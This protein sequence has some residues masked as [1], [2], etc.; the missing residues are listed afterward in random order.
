MITFFTDP[1]LGRNA[2]SHTTPD[3]RKKLDDA[4][5][6][7]AIYASTLY[8]DPTVCVGDL[9]HKAHNPESIIVQGI[10]VASGCDLIIAGNHDL[11]NRADAVPSLGVLA[12]ALNADR[13][14]V[15][16]TDVG[17]TMIYACNI[18]GIAVTSI[19]HHSSQDLFEQ[20]IDDACSFGGEIVCLHAN[21]ESPYT[22]GVNTSLNLTT[23]LA[24]KLLTEFK[25]IVMG[26][27]HNH[28]WEMDGRL[29]IL[30]N[31]HPTSFSDISHKYAW[32]YDTE[33]SQFYKSH[34][35][36]MDYFYTKIEVTDLLDG[37]SEVDIPPMIEFIEVVGK[38]HSTQES[39][40]LAQRMNELWKMH[41][42]SLY[43]LR[44]NTEVVSMATE[45]SETPD[46]SGVLN[47][48]SLKNHLAGTVKGTPLEKP[49]K[50]YAEAS[51]D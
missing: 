3:S 27:E 18:D 6:S 9:F 50:K 22:D 37:L 36:N 32:R 34:L 10:N 1:H 35:W 31:T 49:F 44:N 23:E 51:Y 2:A 29:L 14:M 25:Y 48:E 42:H 43:M 13:N 30:G 26:H 20:A 12:H 46:L 21:F 17:E 45:D 47:T 19:P 11:P 39:H 28:R 15:V 5:Y 8:G 16:C 38:V 41:G 40:T 24:A 7:R 33:N 4:L